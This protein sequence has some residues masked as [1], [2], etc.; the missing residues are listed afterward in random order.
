MARYAEG[1]RKAGLPVNAR[2][3]LWPKAD[4]LAQ[5]LD[6]CLARRSGHSW[7]PVAFAKT[8]EYPKP[9]CECFQHRSWT[10]VA[11]AQARSELQIQRP[12]DPSRT[13]SASTPRIN[14]L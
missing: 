10:P 5:A 11:F 3:G 12:L 6:V 2:V 13:P 8:G 7:F 4:L 14:I 1:L 9:I